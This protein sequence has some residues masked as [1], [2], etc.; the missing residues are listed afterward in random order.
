VNR[1]SPLSSWPT[2]ECYANGT[3]IADRPSVNSNGQLVLFTPYLDVWSNGQWTL[4]AMGPT[5]SG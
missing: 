3:V 2:S 5:Q 1:T 4:A